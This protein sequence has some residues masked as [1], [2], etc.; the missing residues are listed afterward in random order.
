MSRSGYVDD[1]ENPILMINWR[2]AVASAIRG[3]RG[4]AFL[5]ELAAALDAM[6]DKRLSAGSFKHE[7]GCY[8]TLGV[9]GAARGLDMAAFDRDLGG[10]D[11]LDAGK[12][13]KAFGIARAMACEIMSCNDEEFDYDCRLAADPD[14]RRW[15]LMR[16]WV[17]SQIT[18]T[19]LGT[20]LARG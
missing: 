18:G 12:V 6:P 16:D 19:D 10:M 20:D 17:G 2:G 5:R 3:H 8:C 4:Q 15:E 13:G 11:G 1:C 7:N 14:A 9:I